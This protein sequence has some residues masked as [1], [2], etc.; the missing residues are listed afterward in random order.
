MKITGVDRKIIGNPGVRQAMK[1]TARLG[2]NIN[3]K[4]EKLEK[5]T[6]HDYSDIKF[7]RNKYNE[8]NNS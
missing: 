8:K 6:G 3:T 7:K 4:L 5:L 1:E 2:S